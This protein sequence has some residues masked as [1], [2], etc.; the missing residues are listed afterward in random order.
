MGFARFLADGA[1][2]AN[3]NPTAA[4]NLPLGATDCA[5]GPSGWLACRRF[6]G[7]GVSALPP[8]R[9]GFRGLSLLGGTSTECWIPTFIRRRGSLPMFARVWW[10]PTGPFLWEAT[11]WRLKDRH[12]R[13]GASP[14]R[15]GLDPAFAPVV[16]GGVPVAKVLYPDGW[17]L[18]GGEFSHQWASDQ[19]GPCF[20]PGAG[21]GS[22]GVRPAVSKVMV[23]RP[24]KRH[25]WKRP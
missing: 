16:L 2:D 14:E 10:S 20:Q 4:M 13:A 8:K 23:R 25:N 24:G 22:S 17:L 5:R 3:F 15:R 18:V 6:P 11:S 19:C 9:R 7:G 12:D 21:S 1:L